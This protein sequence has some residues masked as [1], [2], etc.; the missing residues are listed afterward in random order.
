VTWEAPAGMLSDV[1]SDWRRFYRT[2]LAVYG[3]TP[4]EYRALYL[5]QLGRCYICRTARG[6]HPDDPKAGG[7]R[8]L[9][10]DHNHLIGGRASVRGLLCSGGDRTCNR[11]IGWL[12]HAALRRAVIYVEEAPAQGVLA[13]LAEGPVSDEEL[14]GMAL[15]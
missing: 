10:V 11:I 8:R 6:K 3:I 7:G 12:D 1:A 4:A 2:V 9:G 15:T 5:A 13:R 14:N